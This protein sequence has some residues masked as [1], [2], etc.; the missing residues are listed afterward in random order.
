M[1]EIKKHYSGIFSVKFWREVD[2]IK[3]DADKQEI[4]SLGVA[5]QN[6]E[7]Y[8]LKRFDDVLTNKLKE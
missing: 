1:K 7:E 2:K 3:D 4:Y 8:V 6:M 5:L